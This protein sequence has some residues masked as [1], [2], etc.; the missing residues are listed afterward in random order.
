MFHAIICVAVMFSPVAWLIALEIKDN[1][2]RRRARRLA[3][4]DRLDSI[5]WYM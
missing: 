2:N 5:V 4:R 1:S 3:V